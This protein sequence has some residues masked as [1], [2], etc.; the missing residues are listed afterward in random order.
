MSWPYWLPS[1]YVHDSSEDIKEFAC[2]LIVT[3]MCSIGGGGWI[4]KAKAWKSG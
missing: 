4:I 3:L 2:A 1:L